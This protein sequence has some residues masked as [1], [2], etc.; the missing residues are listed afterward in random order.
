[1]LGDMFGYFSISYYWE[2]LTLIHSSYQELV[3]ISNSNVFFAHYHNLKCINTN[4][5]WANNNNQNCTHFCRLE[6][7]AMVRQLI[8]P[9]PLPK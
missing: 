8:C 9:I 5:R 3:N 7:V 1:M 6:Y 2:N 4:Q